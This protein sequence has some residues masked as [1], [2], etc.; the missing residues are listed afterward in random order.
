MAGKRNFLDLPRELR[1]LIYEHALQVPGAIIIYTKPHQFMGVV[2]A[3]KNIREK[4]VG[5]PEPVPLASVLS[6]SMMRTCRQFH[7]EC[8]PILYGS[9]NFRLYTPEGDFASARYAPLVRHVTL[10]SSPFAPE[11]LIDPTN[12]GADWESK[13]WP[14]V[15]WGCQRLLRVFPNLQDMTFLLHATGVDGV[16]YRP[17]FID[18]GNPDR[19]ERVKATAAWFKERCSF[20]NENLRRCLHLQL[21]PPPPRTSRT[22]ALSPSDYEPWDISEFYEAFELMKE[23]ATSSRLDF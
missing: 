5:P 22:E 12:G 9:N 2:W 16:V 17:Y 4:S 3:A 20:G 23:Q 8:S 10:G 11:A 14:R 19:A 1:D 18:F 6:T 7:A 15:V 13:F 21:A